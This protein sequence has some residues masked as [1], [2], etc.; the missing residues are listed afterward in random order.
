MTITTETKTELVSALNDLEE[1]IAR[2]EAEPMDWFD[3]VLNICPEIDSDTCDEDGII[4]FADGSVI[5]YRPQESR[6]VLA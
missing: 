1:R 2:F 4:D 5:L 6:W 3:I